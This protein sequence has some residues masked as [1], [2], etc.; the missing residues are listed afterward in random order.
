ME[1]QQH[2]ERTRA[3]LDQEWVELHKWLDSYFD[4][5]HCSAHWLI[6]HHNLG[7]ELAVKRYGEAAREA[8][9]IHII[10][11]LGFVPEGPTDPHLLDQIYIEHAG[12]LRQAE[13]ILSEI[14]DDTFELTRTSE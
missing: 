2:I 14:Y 4:D 11:D 13:T 1:L 10:D 8:A 6:L 5:F 12:V 7:L 3:E 9:R